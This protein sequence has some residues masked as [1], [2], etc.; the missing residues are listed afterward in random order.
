MTSISNFGWEIFINSVQRQFNQ[1]SDV[2]VSLIHFL[3]IKNGFLCIGIGDDRQ[4]ISSNLEL[5]S[6]L[7]PEGWNQMT[8]PMIYKLRYVNAG[9]LYLLNALLTDEGFLIANL[10][11]VENSKVSNALLKLDEI[12]PH[13]S[14]PGLIPNFNYAM[15]KLKEELLEPV[16][17][18]SQKE[19]ETQTEK[20]RISVTPGTRTRNQSVLNLHE[21]LQDLTLGPRPLGRSGSFPISRPFLSPMVP[22]IE[23]YEPDLDREPSP[24]PGYDDMFM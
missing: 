16:Y 11:G 19:C 21:H 12:V 3:L 14:K 15:A 6:E 9:K 5:A 7:M 24:P 23:E 17:K 10:F 13:N 22:A 8:E 1:K 4:L 20:R 2:L 18:G